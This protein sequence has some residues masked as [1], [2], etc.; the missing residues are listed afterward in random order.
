MRRRAPLWALQRSCHDSSAVHVR[1]LKRERR[2]KGGGGRLSR[3]DADSKKRQDRAR[4]RLSLP[5]SPRLPIQHTNNHNHDRLVGANSNPAT[6]P[7]I[8]TQATSLYIINI[9]VHRN[10]SFGMQTKTEASKNVS[11]IDFGDEYCRPAICCVLDM[12]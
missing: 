6:G 4:G 5:L 7:C 8:C 3:Q 12:G 9:V 10:I 2:E 1:T 11:S